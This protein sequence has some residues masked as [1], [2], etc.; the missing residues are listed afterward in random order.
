MLKNLNGNHQITK[1]HTPIGLSLVS[2]LIILFILFKT[3]NQNFNIVKIGNNY[4]SCPGC[5]QNVSDFSVSHDP[6]AIG[7]AC[8]HLGNPFSADS[9]E[10]HKE[11]VPVPGN[12]NTVEQ[13]CGIT[14]CHPLIAENIQKSLMTTGRG[15]V[16]VNQYVFGESLTPDGEGNLAEPKH[17]PSEKHLRN[18]CASCHLAQPKT[19][20]DTVHQLSRGGGCLACHLQYSDEAKA[21]LIQYKNEKK[22]SNVHPSLSIQISNDHC[23]GC[24]SR[25]GRI[26]TNYEGWHETL[27]DSLPSVYQD[28]YRL[29]DDGRIFIKQSPD[30]HH[31][32]GLECIDCHTWRETMGNGESY[33][34]QEQQV[35]ISCRDCHRATLEE[36]TT[37]DKLNDIDKKIVDLR[38][39]NYNTEIFT[40]VKSGNALLNIIKDKDNKF[41]L[42]KKNTGN[43]HPLNPPPPI[44]T[45]AIEGHQRLT[46]KSCHSAWAPQC[47]GCHTQYI[48]SAEAFDHLDQKEVIGGWIEFSSDF[49]ADLPTLG[50]I[51]INQ[52]EVI[53]TFIPGMILNIFHEDG[54]ELFRRL[55]APTSPHT[56][57]LKARDCKSC[58]NNPLALGYGRG[59]L[60]WEKNKWNFIPAFSIN[61]IDSLPE[62]AWIGFLKT[63]TQNV[64][65]RTNTRPLNKNEQQKI[66]LVGACLTCHE[67]TEDNLDNIYSNFETAL[68]FITKEC[69]V[70]RW[71]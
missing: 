65:T 66:L 17:S 35:E 2:I 12:I 45:S 10:A 16:T 18:L 40:T 52:Q 47:L 30:I 25:S 11:L 8:C 54:I 29:L 62:D 42:I 64:S 24:H 27:L 15:M 20:P 63:S 28:K 57:S 21:Q 37:I 36:A 61:P 41:Y 56:T 38:R 43:L 49:Y 51:K 32:K 39:W 53:D 48:P 6:N 4:E 31:E 71:D 44:C 23:F 22:L 70:T 34:H 60:Y 50:V 55:Y 59:K 26:S 1:F 13:T 9:V 5:H 46:C 67:A 33:N 3:E 69:L 7:C 14:D 68:K 58:H 19:M